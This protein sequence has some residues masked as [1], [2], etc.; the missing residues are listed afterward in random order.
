MAG[1]HR[2]PRRV[3]AQKLAAEKSRAAAQEV[4]RDPITTE[5]SPLTK[6]WPAEDGHQDYFARHPDEGY[7]QFVI[8]PKI[9]KL[10]KKL[11]Q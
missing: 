11:G 5:I 8:A 4:F 3:E 1:I 10:A 6:F 7:C 9:H 2:A